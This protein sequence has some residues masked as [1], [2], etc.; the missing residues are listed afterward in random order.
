MTDDINDV[1]AR[2]RA[3]RT[4][5]HEGL[6]VAANAQQL[7]HLRQARSVGRAAMNNVSNAPVA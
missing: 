1:I 7:R 6:S 2:A 5:R 3:G 4:S